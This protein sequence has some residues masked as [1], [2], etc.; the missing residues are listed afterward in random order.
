M[1]WTFD[2]RTGI[3]TGW[4]HPEGPQ[5]IYEDSL[6]DRFV[7]TRDRADGE[8][9]YNVQLVRFRAAGARLGRFDSLTAAQAAAEDHVVT[10]QGGA[11]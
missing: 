11:S 6:G 9:R 5:H 1:K 4:L 2:E 8:Y 10:N 3:H 7:V